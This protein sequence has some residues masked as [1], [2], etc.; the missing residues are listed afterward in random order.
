MN[1]PCLWTANRPLDFVTVK[2]AGFKK[3][4]V[5]LIDC[6][7][8]LKSKQSINQ[9]LH[10]Q[11]NTN[12]NYFVIHFSIKYFLKLKA[13]NCEN[14]YRTIMAFQ[15]NSNSRPQRVR[16][17]LCSTQL[18]MLCFACV[19]MFASATH[20]LQVLDRVYLRARSRDKP[21]K[22]KKLRYSD[23]TNWLNSLLQ[24]N[25]RCICTSIYYRIF[26]NFIQVQLFILFVQTWFV[27]RLTRCKNVSLYMSLSHLLHAF[28]LKQ[29]LYN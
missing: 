12:Y 7:E 3:T 26:F 22:S 17:K 13:F 10:Q 2:S 28:M 4:A 21:E 29:P 9:L 5:F 6:C 14:F 8:T 23:A 24:R 15:L 1:S 16:Y 18:S 27:S 25:R 19:S 20:H 11:K